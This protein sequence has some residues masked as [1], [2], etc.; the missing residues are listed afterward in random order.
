MRQASKR[1]SFVAMMVLALLVAVTMPSTSFGQSRRYNRARS[2]DNRKC[3]KF[4]NCHDARDGRRDRRGR[5]NSFGQQRRWRDNRWSSNNTRRR[6]VR[7]WYGRQDYARTI[8]LRENRS[9]RN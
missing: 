6:G 7:A 4:V 8:R 3:G 5:R 1:R 2:F 9:R